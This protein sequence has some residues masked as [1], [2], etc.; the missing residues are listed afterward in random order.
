MI[1]RPAVIARFPGVVL[2]GARSLPRMRSSLLALP[3]AV[4]RNPIARDQGA[5]E[6]QRRSRSKTGASD[7]SADQ[8]TA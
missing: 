2:G 1:G 7:R 6:A 5:T 3:T 4:A 8:A